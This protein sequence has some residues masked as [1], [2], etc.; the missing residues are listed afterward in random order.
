MGM[1][2]EIG[3]I[4]SDPG[5]TVAAGETGALLASTASGALILL[6]GRRY[7]RIPEPTAHEITP[8]DCKW[9]EHFGH[10]VL[11]IGEVLRIL[12]APEREL[13]SSPITA[14]SRVLAGLPEN[15]DA[16]HPGS[17][18]NIDDLKLAP[19]TLDSDGSLPDAERYGVIQL[20]TYS[21]TTRILIDFETRYFLRA[22]GPGRNRLPY[23]FRWRPYYGST[24][25]VR[26][27]E[28][29]RLWIYAGGHSQSFPYTSSLVTRI[30]RVVN[31]P[32]LISAGRA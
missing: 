14:I 17:V 10:S 8:A 28:V 23:D 27:G 11:V 25:E 3:P 31:P 21:G 12:V 32:M 1:N 26:L 30:E 19:I 16:V 4:T 24:S 15:T 2:L 29:V 18:V 13:V 5:D 7:M 20:T 9:R 22:P 6:D